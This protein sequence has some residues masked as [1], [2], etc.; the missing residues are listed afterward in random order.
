MMPLL[1]VEMLYLEV[2]IQKKKKKTKGEKT[3]SG[4][5]ACNFLILMIAFISKNQGN[6]YRTH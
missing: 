5:R 3:S 6:P 4:N 2:Y 1:S